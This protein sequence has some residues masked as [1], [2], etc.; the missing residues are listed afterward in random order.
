M[1]I[2]DSDGREHYDNGRFAPM[3][4]D[5]DYRVYNR[6]YDGNLRANPSQNGSRYPAREMPRNWHDPYIHG[7][8][9]NMDLIGFSGNGDFRRESGMD[10]SYR[11][12]DEMAYS[13][14]GTNAGYSRSSAV[15]PLDRQTAEEWASKMEN[16]D[17]TKG[18]HWGMDKTEQAREQRGIKCD[19]LQFWLAM[20]MMYSDYCKVAEKLNVSNLDFYACMAHAFLDDKDA[21]PEKLAR[22]Y[23][24]VVKH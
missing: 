16:A 14:S 4:Y 17:G 22:Y 10:A 15:M 23:D 8:E 21:Q 6:Q 20:N 3:Q 1:C 19:P 5:D 7:M 2:R 11:P 12:R 13:R 18:P 24:Y 9:R